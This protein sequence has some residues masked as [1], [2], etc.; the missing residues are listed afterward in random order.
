MTG[1]WSSDTTLDDPSILFPST[2]IR[3]SGGPWYRF[4][5]TSI[6]Q[7]CTASMTAVRA[8]RLQ[9][10]ECVYE[11]ARGQHVLVIW[12]LVQDTYGID[13]YTYTC[14]GCVSK[15]LMLYKNAQ[16]TKPTFLK[17][18]S[19]IILLLQLSL[20]QTKV[21]KLKCFKMNSL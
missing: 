2:K 1:C 5:L 9:L 13:Q 11:Y 21:K 14:T 17:W 4:H 6:L 20:D 16:Q 3:D 19:L 8:T 12:M 15:N 7:T 10:L 18:S